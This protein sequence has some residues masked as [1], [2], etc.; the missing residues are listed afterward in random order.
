MDISA[1]SPSVAQKSPLQQIGI[2]VTKMTMD[3]VIQSSQMLTKSME[4]SVNP[5]LGK[6]IDIKV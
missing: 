3:A 1:L 2:A 4:Q 6:N 5:N